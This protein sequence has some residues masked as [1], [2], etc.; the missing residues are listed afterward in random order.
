MS[1]CFLIE[2]LELMAKADELARDGEQ[3]KRVANL[4]SDLAIQSRGISWG[5]PVW[6][7]GSGLM[8]IGGYQ[9]WEE[10]WECNYHEDDRPI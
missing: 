9:A 1:F 3:L 6:L 2:A 7:I 4:V 8:I 10:H 5:W